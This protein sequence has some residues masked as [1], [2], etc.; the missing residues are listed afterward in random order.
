MYPSSFWTVILQIVLFD[1]FVKNLRIPNLVIPLKDDF[2]R[3]YQN[4]TG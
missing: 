4:C 1:D 2:L 3:H